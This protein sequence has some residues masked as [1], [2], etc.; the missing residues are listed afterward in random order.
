MILQ[1]TGF[2]G[3]FNAIFPSGFRAFSVR[4]AAAPSRRT[5]QPKKT[6]L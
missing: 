3:L 2:Q 6:K 1:A 5:F 4:A